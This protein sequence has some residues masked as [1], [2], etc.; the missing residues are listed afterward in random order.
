MAADSGRFIN[1]YYEN[2]MCLGLVVRSA[3]AHGEILSIS[4]PAIPPGI[5]LL[6]ADSIP[7][8]NELSLF[9]RSMPLLAGQRVSYLGESILLLCGPDERDLVELAR[10]IEI[11]YA[12]EEAIPSSDTA[13]PPVALRREVNV[14]DV[15]R[16]LSQAFQVVEGEYVTYPQE[17]LTSDAQGAFTRMEKQR[18]LVAAPTQWPYHVRNTVAAATGIPPDKVVVSLPEMSTH[19]DSRIWYP[20]LVAAHCALLTQASGKA[21]K[22]VLRRGETGLAGP[23]RAPGRIRIRTALDKNGTPTAEDIQLRLDGG[24]FPLM[25]GELLDRALLGSGG[26]YRNA[27]VRVTAQ[28][29]E[30]SNPPMDAFL[31][32]GLA[33]GAFASE[34]HASR[35]AELSQTDP[36]QW[37]SENLIKE[38]ESFPT[39][40]TP[41]SYPPPEL[42][43]RVSALSDFRR[44]HAAY[45]ML[46]KRRDTIR[47]KTQSLRGIGLSISFQGGGFY[48]REDLEASFSVIVR[49][50]A[51]G[52]LLI[53][54]SGVSIDGAARKVWQDSA[55]R[56]LGIE[57]RSI[58]CK[59][60]VT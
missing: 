5:T 44:K 3:I 29:V 27:N 59:E 55:W 50:E 1:D 11:R 26:P 17:N 60:M 7:G 38:G 15:D 33:Q 54:T 28:V 31:G 35:I 58:V 48:G 53:L 37:K 20:S 13:E 4:Y 12:E 32:L 42:L 52:R 30:S 22:L 40:G 36:F 47:E 6:T 2:E 18:L 19:K 46:K 51:D 9:G 49:L 45:E 10:N 34:T 24:A 43:D 14:G 21:V 39:G 23:R 56:I 41:A 16:A 57:R 25:A 8:K